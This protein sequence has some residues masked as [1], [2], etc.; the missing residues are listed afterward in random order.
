MARP[1]RKDYPGAW[2]HV[3]NRGVARRPMFETRR[4]IRFFLSCVARA[5]RRGQVEV[6]AWCV[7]TTHFHMLVRSPVGEL[8][9]AMR[10]VQSAYARYFN[11][12]RD[13]DGPLHRSRFRSKLVDS[14][15]YRRTLLSYIDANPV[16]AGLCSDARDYTW[17]SARQYV[18]RDGPRWLARNWVE[19]T[20]AGESG[21]R[22]FDPAAYPGSDDARSRDLVADLVMSRLE[23][24]STVDELDSLLDMSPPEIREWL[25]RKVTLAD[26][27]KTEPPYVTDGSITE[28]LRAMAAT[29]GA[30]S[31]RRKRKAVD[32]WRTL[33]VGLLRTLA[34]AS[35][36]AVARRVGTSSV[37]AR[38]LEKAH[39]TLMIEDAM[40]GER[41]ARAAQSALDI[42]RSP[43]RRNPRATASGE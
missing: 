13:R 7:L 36:A 14:L 39:G 32:G 5:V 23:V 19:D 34:H 12:T 17:G 22:Q 9:D 11:R 42:T 26:G 28:V 20:V 16:R 8:S 1:L 4:D 38:R 15:A 31:I 37:H 21:L 24:S 41:A 10:R 40:Y 33:H 2:H 43:A 25:R 30:W 18:S 3:M 6:H 27:V 29:H 35:L